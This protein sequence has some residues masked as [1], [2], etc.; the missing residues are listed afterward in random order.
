MQQSEFDALSQDARVERLQQ[1]A[2]V[3]LAH[4]GL[5]PATLELLKYRENAVFKVT[6]PSTGERFVLRVHRAGYRTDA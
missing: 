2:R 1:L 5:E 3:A 6:Q 4:W